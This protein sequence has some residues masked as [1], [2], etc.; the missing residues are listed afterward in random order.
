VVSDKAQELRGL[1]IEPSLNNHINI[2]KNSLFEIEE[3]E[4]LSLCIKIMQTATY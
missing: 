1:T 2:Y 4:I 3:I